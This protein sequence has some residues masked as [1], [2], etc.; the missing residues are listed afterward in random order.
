MNALLQKPESAASLLGEQPES[1]DISVIIP[2]RN[3]EKTIGRCLESLARMNFRAEDFEV[4]VVD[5]GSTDRT[6]EIAKSFSGRLHL[7]VLKKK[8]GNI[9]AVRNWGARAARGRVLAF[10]DADCVVPSDWLSRAGELFRSPFVGIIGAHGLIP[11]G[12]SWVAR[13]WY[14]EVAIAKRGEV[15]YVPTLDLLVKRS[16]LFGVGG[17][18]ESLETN[19]DYEFCQRVRAAGFVVMGIPEMGV[20]HLGTPQSLKAFY[21]KQ[22]W[23]GT[24]VFRVFLRD[25]SAFHNVRAVFFA[26]YTLL[27]LAGAI[28]GAV[29]LIWTGHSPLLAYSLGALLLAPL[30]LSLRISLRR[31]N[32]RDLFPLTLLHLAYGVARAICL[33]EIRKWWGSWRHRAS[34]AAQPASAN[35][36]AAKAS[37]G[38]E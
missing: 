19:E 3:E 27:C 9:S 29:R 24:H 22:R 38:S 34:Q 23:H 8:D 2:A 36:A 20:V 18:D 15:S 32:G 26:V 12:S 13:A 25:I 11:E 7:T 4:I 37:S 6:E 28:A 5:N 33:L 16:V 1:M 30:L 14:R 21:K 17:F 35:A 31:R 10:T